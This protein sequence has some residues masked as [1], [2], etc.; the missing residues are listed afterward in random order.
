MALNVFA[1][2]KRYEPEL[3][4]AQVLDPDRGINKHQLLAAGD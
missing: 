2:K 4:M 3:A 1:M